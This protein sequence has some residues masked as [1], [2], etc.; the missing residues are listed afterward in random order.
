MVRKR[1]LE[2]PDTLERFLQTSL[3]VML[4]SGYLAVAFSG[5]LD[6]AALAVGAGALLA[7]LLHLAGLVRISIP[8]RWV[9][10]A[11]VLYLFFFPADYFLLSRDFTRAVV[12]LVIFVAAVKLLTSRTRRD[13]VLLG[14]IAFLEMLAASILSTNVTFLLLLVPFL[15]GS[16][17]AL[18]SSEI[19]R[20]L[21]GREVVRAGTASIGRRLGWLT[22]VSGLAILLLTMALFLVLPRT[23]RAALE[24]LMPVSRRVSGFA[25]EVTLGGTGAIARSS[26]PVFHA[27][28]QDELA[29][30]GLHWRGTALAQFDGWKWYNSP[31][32]GESLRVSDDGL[33]QL[34]TD[35]QRRRAGR[36]MA[37]E[38]VLDGNSDYLFLAGLAENLR[39][40]TDRLVR[41]RSGGVKLPFGQSEGLRY[42]VY[43]FVTP[44]EVLDE[45]PLHP[46]SPVARSFYLRL[47]PLDP[48]IAG[49]AATVTAAATD[50]AAR[51]KA[52]ERYLRTRFTY[53]LD[54]SS[55]GTADPLADF[56]FVG[57][58][59][60]CE[61]F[62]SAMAV[63]LRELSIPSRVATG[64]LGGTP[65]PLTKWT[66]VRASDAHAWV[67]AWIPGQGW[68]TFDPTPSAGDSG[69]AAGLL[70]RM[71]L[72]LDAASTLWQEWVVGYDLDRQ[73]TLAFR[74]DQSR[75]LG[76]PWLIL[77]F[78]RAMALRLPGLPGAG[79]RSALVVALCVV[80]AAGLLLRRRIVALMGRARRAGPREDSSAAVVHEAARLYRG[81][82]RALHKRGIEKMP[83]QTAGEF[84][85]GVPDGVAS[86]LVAEFTLQYESVRF[87]RRA[88]ALSALEALLH[89][90]ESLPR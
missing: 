14:V 65:N 28:F 72:Y 73:L 21:R 4:A 36:R 44:G 85:A 63:M 60:H 45:A 83:F 9:N 16:L 32:A 18:S 30:S 80:L 13:S 68:T 33:V 2:L 82:L 88:E 74:V 86:P 24:R 11:T 25:S 46:L 3:L 40:G 67:E 7:R 54:S 12:H 77:T 78:R 56:L 5:E 42:A 10:A 62:A 69:A 66:V 84:A 17:A 57:Q 59:G 26:V 47:P 39:V 90:I 1:P 49:L 15:G 29:P 58:A 20:P 87:G 34:V 76:V 27:L 48:R 50:D 75:R 22:A 41:D 70:A 43:S 61:Y 37:Y 55:S 6:A 35:D 79:Q 38:V 64:F 81:M 31:A 19:G 53:S 8:V 89:R 52:I 71:N 51:A 23:A